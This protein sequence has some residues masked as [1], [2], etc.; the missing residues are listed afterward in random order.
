MRHRIRAIAPHDARPARIHHDTDLI[1]PFLTDA[2]H[3]VGFASGVA[4]P[5]T[6]EE[7]A[8]LVRD[9]T[10]VLPVGAQSS[11]TGGATPRGEVVISTRA[12]TRLDEPRDGRVRVGAG[13]SIAMVQQ[14][15]AE[16]GLYYPPAPTYEGASVGGVVATNAAGPSTFKYGATRRWIETVTV[17]LAS[18]DILHVER[19]TTVAAPGHGFEITHASGRATIVPPLTYRMPEVAKLSAGYYAEGPS[20]TDLVDLFVGSEGTLGIVV[21][22]TLRVIPRPD[23]SIVLLVC[24]DDGEALAVTRALREDAR[25]AWK[26]DTDALDVAAVE[27]ID[28]AALAVTPHDAFAR[29]GVS[30]PGDGSVMLIAQLDIARDADEPFARLHQLL[31]DA[32]SSADARVA[33][34]GDERGA[35]ALLS[36]REAV[37]S[38]VNAQIARVKAAVDPAIEKTAGDMSVP[39]ERVADSLAL[40]RDAFGRRGLRHAI[41]GHVSDGNLHP[42][43]IP[44]SLDD[45]A[46]GREALL[47]IGRA[48]I[49]MGGAPLAEHGVGRSAIKQQLLRELYGDEGIAQMQRVKQALDP[50]WKLSPGVL[51]PPTGAR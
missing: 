22:A 49:A 3:V 29:A 14:R 12:L 9:A 44:Q 37:P 36:L 41:W 35:A 1:A 51:F 21:E 15:L 45:V 5:A 11:L 24:R 33:A 39:F 19:G 32:G 8:G 23:R 42:N 27:Y 20:G 7:V 26:C 28:A 50:D 30:R 25:R 10:R 46:Q 2:A 6:L 4:V 47:E 40:Y 31:Q 38:A 43:V 13:V 34:T 48:V 18:G 16:R 17:V